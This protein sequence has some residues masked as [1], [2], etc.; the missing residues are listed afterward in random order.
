M[1]GKYRG[2]EV[3][4]DVDV[5]DVDSSRVSIPALWAREVIRSLE[6][7]GHGATGKGTRQAAR[8]ARLIR[9]RVVEVSK[10]YGVLSRFTSYVGVEKRP[11][12]DR[13]K[14]ELVLRKVP[15]L[16]T[17]GWHGFGSVVGTTLAFAGPDSG[18][19]YMLAPTMCFGGPRL[20]RDVRRERRASAAG[21]DTG[22]DLV[23]DILAL[24]QPGGGL[25][26]GAALAAKI[27]VTLGDVE[28]IAK[29]MRI[30]G[31]AD[32]FLI[33]STA[34]LLAVLVERFA[35]MRRVWAGPVHKTRKWFDDLVEEKHPTIDG[36]P[37]DAWMQRFVA[38]N[39]TIER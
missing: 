17:V 36:E 2:S 38:A 15:A 3:E 18:V 8:K 6:D 4:W 9:E 23:M 21:R 20:S 11:E 1:K 14:G 37:L 5:T 26:L 29:R 34:L 32:R 39:V 13:V 10:K 19:D 35:D 12:K 16:V 27:G 7:A 31:R 28:A 25:R 22:A 33:A 30:A 24:Q